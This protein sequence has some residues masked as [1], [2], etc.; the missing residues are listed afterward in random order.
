MQEIGSTL[1][2]HTQQRSGRIGIGTTDPYTAIRPQRQPRPV[3]HLA[4]GLREEAALLALVDA[5]PPALADIGAGDGEDLPGSQ[6]DLA[7][8][9]LGVE[10]VQRRR[11]PVRGIVTVRSTSGVGSGHGRCEDSRDSGA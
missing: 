2:S 7:R 6:T 11:L 4:V 5:L 9:R 1:H 8:V 10:V 3:P